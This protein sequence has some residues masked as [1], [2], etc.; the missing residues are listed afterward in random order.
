MCKLSW[1]LSLALA[2]AAGGA[3]ISAAHA[4]D[5]SAEITLTDDLKPNPLAFRGQITAPVALKDAGVPLNRRNN[6]CRYLEYAKV[7]SAPQVVLTLDKPKRIS[8][9]ALP[10]ASMN[11]GAY[12]VKEDRS[13][14]FCADRLGRGIDFNLA[15]GRWLVYFVP[16]S[17]SGKYAFKLGDETRPYSVADAPAG[18][19][20][21]TVEAAFKPNPRV[22]RATLAAAGNVVSDGT[23]GLRCG[24]SVKVGEQPSLV[25]ELKEDRSERPLHLFSSHDYVVFDKQA[26][27]AYCVSGENG[28]LKLKAGTHNLYA[29]RGRYHGARG[30]KSDD[31][32]LAV[33]DPGRALQYVVAPQ[34]SNTTSLPAKLEKPVV[35]AGTSAGERVKHPM[36]R[37]RCNAVGQTP[38]FYVQTSGLLEDVQVDLLGT[39]DKVRLV[40]PIEADGTLKVAANARA[41]EVRKRTRCLVSSGGRR[42]RAGQM[43]L[44]GLYAAYVIGEG[45]APVPYVAR[46]YQR[47]T[48]LDPVARVAEPRPDLSLEDRV[49]YRWYPDLKVDDYKFSPAWFEG[50]HRFWMDV[51][52]TLLVF[53]NTDRDDLKLKAGT[54]LV[55]LEAGQRPR[56]MAANGRRY[57]V[58]AKE[59]ALVPSGP[60]ASPEP[61]TFNLSESDLKVFLSGDALEAFE[62]RQKKFNA[63]YQKVLD[64]LD[65]DGTAGRYDIVT[66]RRGR[67][68]KVEGMAAKN[69]RIAGKRCKEKAYDKY[70]KGVTTKAG[71]AAD[72]REAER[73]QAVKARLEGLFK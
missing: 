30:G 31:A 21:L 73:A 58:K 15:V 28:V 1:M 38:D 66:Y 7:P 35:I 50:I 49:V 53:L 24:D 55:L 65:P 71:A 39:T 10:E 18:T 72:E 67:I 34:A 43:T 37:G 19:P 41:E 2:L 40:G 8:M 16:R 4:Q 3:A 32:W 13:L 6:N 25:L 63:C 27:K 70:V 23:F 36:I 60:M 26:G 33:R 9:V 59:L 20:T 69:R 48:A 51:P 68:V 52:K 56:A 22:F 44:D 61:N 54:P 11:P 64:K 62:K 17:G 42:H 46:F 45:N 14:H 12:I 5:R 57:T 29:I 47:K